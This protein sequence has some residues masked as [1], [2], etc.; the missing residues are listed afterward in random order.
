M[1]G[2]YKFVETNATERI[3]E[4][5]M[6]AYRQTTMGEDGTNE[7]VRG[8]R[9]YFSTGNIEIVNAK[10]YGYDGSAS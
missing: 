6:A 5:H 4:A 8:L 10:M 7:E 2:Q 9:F 1:H 3:S